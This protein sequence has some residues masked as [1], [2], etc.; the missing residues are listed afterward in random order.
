[1]HAIAYVSRA[2]KP[3][4]Q[5]DLLALLLDC[6]TRNFE[7]SITGLLMYHNGQFAQWLE[8]EE[9]VAQRLYRRICE[10]SRHTDIEL[11][12]ARPSGSR[13]FETWSMGFVPEDPDRVRGTLGFV[14]FSQGH[15]MSGIPQSN[16]SLLQMLKIFRAS[17]RPSPQ[18]ARAESPS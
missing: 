17:I 4:T 11:I 12:G 16:D 6:R 2:V 15:P 14:D 1:M 8:G 18:P 9:M 10:D 7:R 3:F 5:R 13:V